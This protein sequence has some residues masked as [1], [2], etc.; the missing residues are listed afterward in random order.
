MTDRFTMNTFRQLAVLIA[1][2]S[3]CLLSA[4]HAG[5]MERMPGQPNTPVDMEKTIHFTLPSVLDNSPINSSSYQGT[6][7]LVTFFAKWCPPCMEE[8]PSLIALHSHYKAKGFSVIGLSLEK[9]DQQTV[10]N[11]IHQEKINYPVL[12]ADNAV[13]KEFGGI[14]GI[15]TSFLLDRNQKILQRYIGYV[16]LDV[17]EEDI[18][19]ALRLN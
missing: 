4:S 5:S 15:P 1:V 2:L 16:S 11:L 3:S 17:L 10:K 12:K 14:I 18:R 9:G 8:I 6:I 19:K 13:I 7:L